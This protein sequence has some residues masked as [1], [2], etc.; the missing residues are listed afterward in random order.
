MKLMM[1]KILFP[2]ET[3][4]D[5]YKEAYVYAVKFARNL[6][7]ELIMLNVFKIDEEN[8]QTPKA[9]KKII[10]DKYYKAYQEIIRFNKY[11]LSNYVKPEA[12]LRIKVDYRFLHGHMINELTQ[13]ISEEKIDLVVLPEAHQ[14]ELY[15][16]IVEVIWHDLSK[17]TPFS[18]LLIPSHCHYDPIKSTAF[19]TDMK[20]LDH[21]AR[22]VNDVLRYSKVFDAKV[23][24]LHIT[25][26]KKVQL[27][28]EK[29][30]FN[31]LTQLIENS[32]EH[33]FQNLVGKDVL[34]LIEEYTAKNN[35]QL[36]FVVRHYHYFLDA[37]FHMDLSDKI[38]LRS[39]IPVLV[40]KEKTD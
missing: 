14:K 17:I 16:W 5:I 18:L 28:E 26:K 2:F 19:V 32:H 12:E 34:D 8:A 40:M 33:V 38:S 22:Y 4:Q 39:R 3:N 37:L 23:H 31:K 6:G 9:Y 7:A 11:Y 36:L 20:E 15:R 24:F 35:V 21:L 13:I 29:V 27:T 1:K 10:R 30:D 25:Q